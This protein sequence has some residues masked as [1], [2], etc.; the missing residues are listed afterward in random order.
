MTFDIDMSGAEISRLCLIFMNFLVQFLELFDIL[1]SKRL[2]QTLSFP[3]IFTDVDSLCILGQ[4]GP[5][6]H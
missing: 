3:V 5:L 6:A 1:M 4:I 2:K